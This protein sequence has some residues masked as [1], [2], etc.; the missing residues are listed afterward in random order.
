M[1]MAIL[2]DKQGCSEQLIPCGLNELWKV[3]YLVFVG[4]ALFEILHCLSARNL[5]LVLVGVVGIDNVV[6]QLD[7][8][9][10]CFVFSFL[11]F[12]LTSSIEVSPLTA[13]GVDGVLVVH[14]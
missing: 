11:S 14:F 7:A 5:V 6:C 3:E 2:V 10:V 8:V 1:L 13:V 9:G 12:T 4:N